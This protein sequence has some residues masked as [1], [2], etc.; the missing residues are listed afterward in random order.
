MCLI[1]PELTAKSILLRASSPWSVS[2]TRKP[3]FSKRTS[4]QS[5]RSPLPPYQVNNHRISNF[6]IGSAQPSS[7]R[8]SAPA[9]PTAQLWTRTSSPTHPSRETPFPPALPPYP[10]QRNQAARYLRGLSGAREGWKGGRYGS[11]LSA[12]WMAKEDGRSVSWLRRRRRGWV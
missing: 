12:R 8:T 6:L 3:P 5:W 1:P 11:R 4:A 10:S 2:V 7:P 9:Q